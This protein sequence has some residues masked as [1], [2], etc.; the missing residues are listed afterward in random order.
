MGRETVEYLDPQE[1]LRVA[2]FVNRFCEAMPEDFDEQIHVQDAQEIVRA[3]DP[4]IKPTKSKF[5]FFASHTSKS[6]SSVFSGVTDHGNISTS[7]EETK[8]R[9]V[10]LG[11]ILEYRIGMYVATKRS[12]R[13]K[14]T[15]YFEYFWDRGEINEAFERKQPI[16]TVTYAEDSLEIASIDKQIPRV[17]HLGSLI[18]TTYSTVQLWKA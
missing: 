18:I 7:F 9:K 14:S 16:T 12:K 15:L 8:T 1:Q 2:A 6:E 5:S 3:L 13:N 10:S 11:K 17:R 4:K